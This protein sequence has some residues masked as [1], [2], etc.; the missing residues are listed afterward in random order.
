M[1]N[2]D[3]GVF[4]QNFNLKSVILAPTCCKNPNDPYYIDLV[5]CYEAFEACVLEK[6]VSPIFIK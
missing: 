4:C 3:M 2:K 1:K 6:Q 5:L